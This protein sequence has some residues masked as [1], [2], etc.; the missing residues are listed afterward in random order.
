MFVQF[1]EGQKRGYCVLS[2]LIVPPQYFSLVFLFFLSTF[3]SE[4]RARVG[5]THPPREVFCVCSA[6][7]TD[8]RQDKHGARKFIIPQV[9]SSAGE[10]LSQLSG[11]E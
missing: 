9:V 8:E 2:S 7:K 1:P 10:K 4:S 6:S 11:L 5:T 3:N